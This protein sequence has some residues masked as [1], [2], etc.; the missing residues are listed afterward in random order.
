MTASSPRGTF[1]QAELTAEL[2]TRCITRPMPVPGATIPAMTGDLELLRAPLYAGAH[3]I[4]D[5]KGRPGECVQAAGMLEAK[6]GLVRA[7]IFPLRVV[8]SLAKRLTVTS[9]TTLGHLP[10]LGSQCQSLGQLGV[11][12]G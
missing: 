11:G 2:I 5:R 10:L 1:S 9:T 4:A 8:D 12:H 7:S 6:K 3:L